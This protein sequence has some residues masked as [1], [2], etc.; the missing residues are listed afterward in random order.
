MALVLALAAG[1]EKT[2]VRYYVCDQDF[3]DCRLVA[4]FDDMDSCERYNDM[5]SWFCNL[6]T[7][8]GYAVCKIPTVDELSG[9]ARGKCK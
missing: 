4:R 7:H 2:P 1:C 8:P 5:N 9:H 6:K 3:K